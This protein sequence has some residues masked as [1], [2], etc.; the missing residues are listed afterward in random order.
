[1]SLRSTTL[2]RADLDRGAVPDNGYSIH[3][4]PKVAGREINLTTDPPP[5]LVVEVDISHTDINKL[6]LYA[7]MGVPEF[8]RFDG[9]VWQIYQLQAGDYVERDRSPTFPQVT[10][11]NLYQFL[12]ACQQDEVAAEI[13]FCTWVRQQIEPQ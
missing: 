5:D 1:M 4:Q 3:N 10:K 8:W 11:A 2:D 12:T 13:N 9:Q 7:T 6:I